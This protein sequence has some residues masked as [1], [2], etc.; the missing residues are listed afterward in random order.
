[1][2]CRLFSCRTYLSLTILQTKT[3]AGIFLPVELKTSSCLFRAGNAGPRYLIRISVGLKPRTLSE[4]WGREYPSQICL[5]RIS[6]RGIRMEPLAG[7]V[8]ERYTLPH[9]LPWAS[10][11]TASCLVLSLVASRTWCVYPLLKTHPFNSLEPGMWWSVFSL[12][13]PWTLLYALK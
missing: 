11:A 7:S 8:P 13:G 12:Y 10:G 2:K 6:H 9:P 4:A 5:A 1:M 3:T